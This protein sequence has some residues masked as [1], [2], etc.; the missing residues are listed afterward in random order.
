M[1]IATRYDA[2]CYGGSIAIRL[3]TVARTFSSAI[4]TFVPKIDESN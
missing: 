1:E 3:Q 4:A 2:G